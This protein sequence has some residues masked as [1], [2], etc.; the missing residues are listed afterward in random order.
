MNIDTMED[1]PYVDVAGLELHITTLQLELDRKTFAIHNTQ[2]MWL[3]DQKARNMWSQ[4]GT[5]AQQTLIYLS[6]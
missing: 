4:S 2:N 1:V 5:K 3:A 6:L